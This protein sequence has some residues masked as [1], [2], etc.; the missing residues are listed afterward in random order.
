MVASPFSTAFLASRPAATITDGFEV[1]VQLVMAAITTEPCLHVGHGAVAD[2]AKPMLVVAV[3]HR[4][5]PAAFFLGFVQRLGSASS[6][7]S[8]RLEQADAVLRALRAGHARLD[9][10]EVELDRR[11]VYSASGVPGVVEQALLARVG[12]D[13]RD[14]RRSARPVRRR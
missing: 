2:G 8:S 3:E 4:R 7:D 1:L 11:R 5:S 12:L 13:Q 10:G 9:G 14:L 6:N